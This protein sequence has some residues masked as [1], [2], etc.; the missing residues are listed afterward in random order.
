MILS[1]V[2]ESCFWLHRYVERAD[3]TARLLRVNRAFVLDMALPDLERWHPIVIVAGE[4]DRFC[5]RHGEEAL[6]DGERVQDYMTWDEQNPVSI[7]AKLAERLGIGVGDVLSFVIAG[8]D[9]TARV[10]STRSVEWDSFRPN[11]YMIFPHGTLDAF[12][13]TAMTSFY[14]PGDRGQFLQALVQRFPAVTVLDVEVLLNEVR[15][16]LNQVTLAV[17]YILGFVLLSRSLPEAGRTR[18]PRFRHSW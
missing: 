9:L 15:R 5:A 4:H 14:L 18:R 3:D 6:S 13:A 17:E 16:I 12:P 7:E 10:R 11:F 8:Q 1:R 2:A